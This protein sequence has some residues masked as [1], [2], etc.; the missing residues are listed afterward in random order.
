MKQDMLWGVFALWVCV[1]LA[2]PATAQFGDLDWT[3]FNAAGDASATLGDDVLSV[4]GPEGGGGPASAF[5]MTTAPSSGTVCVNVN[6]G[7]Q[8]QQLGFDAAA[9]VLDGTVTEIWN[10]WDYGQDLL[11]TFD[12]AAGSSFGLGATSVDSSYGPVD[13]GYGSAVSRVG[14]L[15]G[16]GV[17][18]FAVGAPFADEGGF[19]AGAVFAVSGADRSL[20]RVHLGE[21]VNDRFGAS[22]AAVPDVDGDG[23]TDL[24]VGAPLNDQAGNKAGKA[25]LY[26][27]APAGLSA[28]NPLRGRNW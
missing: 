14:D 18:D 21:A 16:D 15:N 7:I 1:A 17:G 9:Y 13:D 23:L 12:V 20:I 22:L 10:A 19:D 26:S 6:F 24:L 28:T 11:L 3:F 4:V 8:D 2:T 25:N 27:G 5:S